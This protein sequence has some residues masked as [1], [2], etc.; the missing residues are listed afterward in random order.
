MKASEHGG[1]VPDTLGKFFVARHEDEEVHWTGPFDTEEEALGE[2]RAMFGEEFAI[3]RGIE[4]WVPD[5]SA[6]AVLEDIEERYYDGNSVDD[7]E[8]PL[9]PITTNGPQAQDLKRRLNAVFGA[10]LT[11]HNLWPDEVRIGLVEQVAP[12]LD[13]HEE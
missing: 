1:K 10:W 13:D 4:M 12:T 11:E 5:I 2:G 7:N 9:F 3:G 6:Q 8:Q